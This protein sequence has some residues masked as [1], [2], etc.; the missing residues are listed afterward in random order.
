M[1]VFRF[2]EFG[3][4]AI[5][6]F[7]PKTTK[8]PVPCLIL[9]TS[10]NNT[11]NNMDEQ[12]NEQ[13]HQRSSAPPRSPLPPR[14]SRVAARST[15]RR[16][17][18]VA[19]RSTKRCCW[20]EEWWEEEE[21]LC[22][23]EA[24]ALFGRDEEPGWDDASHTLHAVNVGVLP[25]VLVRGDCDWDGGDD[26]CGWLVP[27]RPVGGGV[28][29]GGRRRP[30]GGGVERRMASDGRR[31]KRDQ[32]VDFFGGSAEWDAAVVYRRVE[33]ASSS[34]FR[35]A[36]RER[37][38]E[39]ERKERKEWEEHIR[40]YGESQR[41]RRE[42]MRR[43]L[44]E[45][46][47]IQNPRK[48]REW[49]GGGGVA[50]DYSPTDRSRGDA[51]YRAGETSNVLANVLA[52]AP[53]RT[54]TVGRAWH[55]F[56]VGCSRGTACCPV[57]RIF[58]ATRRALKLVCTFL[59]PTIRFIHRPPSSV[60]LNR[61]AAPLLG[62]LPRALVR[63]VIV[64]ETRQQ[65]GG[66]AADNSKDP[67]SRDEV[68]GWETCVRR[69][70]TGLPSCPCRP[71]HGG[72]VGGV[73]G[74]RPCERAQTPAPWEEEQ[75]AELTGQRALELCIW[76]TKREK[77]I[78]AVAATAKTRKKRELERL[79]LARVQRAAAAVLAAAA[80]S[81][82]DAAAALSLAAFWRRERER[83][84]RHDSMY[85]RQGKK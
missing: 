6:Q 71:Y 85:G 70:S 44:R 11:N 37:R 75:V 17:L 31:Y 1:K 51:G 22:E 23:V 34:S 59:P 46:S 40:S 19:A 73:G 60:K 64:A 49:E 14:T 21:D 8:F 57:L 62:V 18:L 45:R 41:L 76:A 53:P 74:T 26:G 47:R 42:E 15:K 81:A 32:F 83:R 7:S 4:N 43:R 84:S 67:S 3:L 27:R 12:Q 16:S 63:G 36:V 35:S 82:A 69:L 52:E 54:P 38:A 65:D 66:S 68:R 48:M 9:Q 80:K 29:G 28:E 78:S 77:E 50:R 20:W 30:V 56:L 58:R 2:S 13:Q 24:A 33:A 5:D 79:V 10:M 25:S 55:T 39:K 61:H 72:G